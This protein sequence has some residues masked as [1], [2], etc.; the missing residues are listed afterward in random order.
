M[1]MGKK[2]LHQWPSYGQVQRTCKMKEIR[3]KSEDFKLFKY[4]NYN[5]VLNEL[6]LT[7]LIVKLG[8]V[9][10]VNL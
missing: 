10:V 3:I 5:V 9:R 4:V 8:L 6:G 7:Y 2:V 1:E